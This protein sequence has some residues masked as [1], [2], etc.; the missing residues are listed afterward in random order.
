MEREPGI[1][2]SCQTSFALEMLFAVPFQ[3]LTFYSPLKKKNVFKI[4]FCFFV[5]FLIIISALST[6]AK[7]YVLNLKHHQIAS[8][9]KIFEQVFMISAHKRWS[10]TGFPRKLAQQ[11]LQIL[12]RYNPTIIETDIAFE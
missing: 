4:K 9:F 6:Q 12:F 8:F 2:C 5:C 3:F 10:M 11:H 7:E 1:V